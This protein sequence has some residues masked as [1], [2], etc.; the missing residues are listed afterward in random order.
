MRFMRRVLTQCFRKDTDRDGWIRINY[1][2]FM[3][4]NLS[5]AQ[6]L[7]ANADA[8]ILTD[9]PLVGLIDQPHL[10]T[11]WYTLPIS[12]RR[13]PITF[14]HSLYLRECAPHSYRRELSI[15]YTPCT[16]PFGR[17][18]TMSLGATLSSWSAHFRISYA[19]PLSRFIADTTSCFP[20][21]PSHP[22][23]PALS[24]KV[25]SGRCVIPGLLP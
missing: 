17:I 22:F 16:R 21:A 24:A 4:V 25:G 6:G 11:T 10:Y 5:M 19:F 15:A 23:A 18:L 13:I 9:G 7:V 3:Q 1:E 14:A 2:D 20:H 8:L 12:E